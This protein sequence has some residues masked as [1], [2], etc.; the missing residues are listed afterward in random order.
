M[1]Y[2]MGQGYW[3]LHPEVHEPTNKD[4]RE[5]IHRDIK[6]GNILLKYTPDGPIL[7]IADFGCAK[8]VD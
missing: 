2:Q 1:I 7:K 5:I 3:P 4:L 6:P 8:Y